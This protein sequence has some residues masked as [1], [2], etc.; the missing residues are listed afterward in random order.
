MV[1]LPT[2]SIRA[3]RPNPVMTSGP[4]AVPHVIKGHTLEGV[5]EGYG[6]AS[7]SFAT[8]KLNVEE[9]IWPR[10]LPGPAFDVP[11]A[12]IMELLVATG[13]RLTRDPDGLLAQACEQM[14]RT[15]PLDP[16]VLERDYARLGALFHR[17]GMQAQ[18][19]NELG[20]PAGLDV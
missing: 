8:P 11:V 10:T 17:G 9:L 16:G 14:K 2:G 3:M 12:Q 19:N 15:S 6:P 18:I 7:A 5:A 4:T 20:A 1:D 13:E